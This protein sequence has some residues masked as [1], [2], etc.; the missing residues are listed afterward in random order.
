MKSTLLIVGHCLIHSQSNITG[1]AGQEP[2]AQSGSLSKPQ[3]PSFHAW[4]AV[5]VTMMGTV[6]HR[7]G[8]RREKK[9]I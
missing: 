2:T 7:F 6:K 5:E 9:H 8:K 4:M 3:F 1:E